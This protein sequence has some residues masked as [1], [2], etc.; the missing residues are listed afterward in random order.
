LVVLVGGLNFCSQGYPLI[1]I[2]RAHEFGADAQTIGLMF[3]SGGIGGLLG[4]IAA[5]RLQQRFGTGRMVMVASWIWVLTWPPFALAPN[6]GWLAV[7]NAIGW[8]IVPIHT[9][10]QLTYR[11][12]AIPDTLQGRVNSVYRLIAFGG[13]PLALAISGVLLQS[14]GAANTVWLITLPQ[15]ILVLAA[16]VWGHSLRD[17]DTHTATAP[18]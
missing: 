4:G 16:T 7:V 5:P 15:L 14:F 13:Q 18:A 10:T 6:L 2:V 1:L 12:R 11:L 17:A 9:I 3:A 8:I